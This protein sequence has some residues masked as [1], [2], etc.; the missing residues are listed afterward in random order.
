MTKKNLLKKV[1]SPIICVALLLTY[2]PFSSS[3]AAEGI[4]PST[5]MGIVTDPGT[6]DSF[7]NMMGTDADGN[8]YA[9]RVWVDKSVYKNGDIVTLNNRN[10][11]GS[12]FKVSLEDDEAFQVVF[13]ALGSTM[14]TKKTMISSGPLDVVLI[15]DTSTSMEDK[16]KNVT[17]LERT[18]A[19]ANGLIDDILSNKDT[20]ISVV[21]YNVDS[22]TVIPLAPYKNGVDLVVTNYLNNNKPDAG[23]VTA[24]DNDKN[25]LGKDNGYT[26]GTNLQSGIDRGFNILANA[27]NTENRT[28][29]A[30]V[31]T[32]G[33]ATLASKEGYYE[34]ESQVN[35][36]GVTATGRNLYLTTLLN[37]AYNKTKVEEKYNTD[38]LVYTVGVDITT[39]VRA[40]LLM[41][42]ADTKNG[43]NANNSNGEVKKAYENFGKWANGETVTYSGWT[44]DHN[45]PTQNGLITD[46][47]IAANVNYS[48]VYYDVTSTA[49][50]DAFKQIYEE[51][52]SG[53]F[54]PISS[55]TSDVGGTGVDDTPLIYVDFIGQYMEIKSIQSVSIF[56]SS[57]GVIKNADGT[58]S[59]D[60]GTGVNP[61]TNEIWK[62][63]EDITFDIIPQDDGTQKFE[64]RINQE[65]LP[66]I[67]EQAISETVGNKT[68]S[69]INEILQDPLRVYY[70]VGLDSDILLPNGDINISKIQGYEYIDADNGTV[71]FYSNRFGVMN[72][73]DA[74]DIV[75]KG[76]AHVGFLPSHENRYYYNQSNHGI[77][78]K[79]TDKKTGKDVTIP[80]NNE[81]G[82]VW[83]D[84]QYDLTWMTYDEYKTAD[85]DTKVYTYVTFYR[86]TPDTTDA[87]NAAEQVTYLRYADWKYIKE[88]V[89]FYDQTAKAYLNNGNAIDVKDVDSVISA[90]KQNNP[91]AEL[92]AVL[93]I[94][95]H[96]SSRLHNM[97]VNKSENVT[98]TAVERYTPEYTYETAK[99]HSGNEVVV[100]LGNN[101]KLTL[102]LDTGIALTKNV[103]EAIG[104]PFDTYALTVTVPAGVTANPEVVDANGKVV[105]YTYENN[106]LTVNVKAKET[107]Y[108]S[109]IPGGTTCEIDEII[110]GDYYIQ[111][112]TDTVTIPN[113]SEV[114]N[115]AEQFVRA[116]VTNVPHKHGNLFITKEITSNHAVPES[117][118]NELFDITVSL[119]KDLANR[120]FAVKDMEHSESYEKTTDA[121]GNLTLQI[122]ARQTIEILRIP[123]GTNV[124]VTENN[125]DNH[126]AVSY[127][128]RNHSGEDADTDNA[129]VIPTEG[130]ATA[131]VINHYTPS[132]VSVDL[133]I[134]G[135]KNFTIEGNHQGGKFT[136]KTQKWNGTTWEDI[137]GKTAETEYDDNESGTKNFTIE[138]VLD[139]IVFDEVGRYS[140]QVVEVKGNV[141]NITYDRTLYTFVVNVTDNGGQLVAN[142]TDL[143]NKPITDGSYE[144]VFNNTYH[145]APVSLDVKKIVDNKSGD[146]TI[147]PAG[148]EFKAISTDANWN[149]LTGEDASS[150][151]IYSD[152]VGEA[153]FNSVCT[154]AGTYYFVLTEVDKGGAG[155]TYSD[156]EYHITVAVSADDATGNL[157]ASLNIVKVG[158]D[159]EH[160]IASVDVNDATKGAVS[161]VNTYDPKDV[162][163]D[164]DGVVAKDL[165]GKDLQSNQ[166][167]FY[168]Y[169]NEDR[170]TPVLEGKNGLNG[171]V[172]LVD[173]N[174]VLTFTTV[175][176]FEYDIVEYIPEN[177]VYDPASGKYILNGMSYDATIYD[178]VVEVIN[179]TATGELKAYYYFEDAVTNLVTFYNSYKVE[180]V[181]YT[182][183]GTKILHGR[184]PKTGE[185]FFELYEGNILKETVSNKSDGSFTFNEIIYIA[186][187]EYTYTVKEKNGNKAG[188]RYDGVNNPITIVVTVVDV[189]GVLNATAS[190]D[191]AN[192]KFE[193]Y[194]VP[195]PAKVVFN[196]VKELVGGE[197]VDN[198][199]TFNLYKTDYFF[200]ITSDTAELIATAKNNNGTF[201][202]EKEFSETGTHYF[203]VAENTTENVLSNVVYDRTKHLLA[204]K[205]SDIGDGQLK[206]DVTNV[207]TGVVTE[208]DALV[209][210]NVAFTNAAFD[211][212]TKKEVY[213][214]EDTTTEINGKE[215][216][217]GDVLTYFITYTNY[218]GE[219]VV[220]NITD[221]IPANATYVEG[222]AT[223]DGTFAGD[224]VNW[225]LNVDKEETVTVSFDVEVVGANSSIVNKAIIRDG[226]NTYVTNE[227]V[228]TVYKPETHPTTETPTDTP[229][230]TDTPSTGESNNLQLWIV[231]LFVSCGGFATVGIY[232]KKRKTDQNK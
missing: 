200:D 180:Y 111:S 66:I 22:E 15:L 215:V 2:I 68:T 82:I 218:T 158:S 31:L 45:Y 92:Y 135:T 231:L 3:L 171:N 50:Q 207:K 142:I 88:S 116:S 32:D 205:V 199:F 40:K 114:L 163:V 118:L 64:I 178:L 59:V 133:D 20:R 124:T 28:P 67:M 115:G 134:I 195:N 201:S 179:D 102:K 225:I 191:N 35:N 206:A 117:V 69:T 78:T 145:T 223:L 172:N 49:L 213:L 24:Y 100:W 181:K 84:D 151:S 73:A 209:S 229:T 194:Y 162:I 120:S 144:V 65:I 203:V 169:K 29:V 165:F 121:S 48:D 143:N 154:K 16:Y 21:T 112:K 160:E 232:D 216:N 156:A 177:A 14:T 170:T 76:D 185:F 91:N 81:Y 186:E 74:S 126:F 164:L 5:V 55:S 98:Q 101:G 27:T 141:S 197:L 108:I 18:I 204:V 132:P 44:F 63:N 33:Q 187:G 192:V 196:G 130:S 4:N 217:V 17:R 122:K 30:I 221:A 214:A 8:R 167:T 62:T 176:K 211:G 56:G 173:F 157:T 57:Y 52:S 99:D 138:N 168:V 13:S 23:V 93:G 34:L 150:I 89:A 53:A 41:N 148:F 198:A 183:S 54:N 25:V 219:N 159:N 228:N 113:V 152:A 61:T 190:V 7:E 193:N 128:T 72:P 146:D 131:V 119:G 36:A 125:S 10:E 85:D 11:T 139:G 174:D 175:G 71:S 226:V 153:R 79:I 161:F 80:E 75:A 43:F 109:G 19:A 212:V 104:N 137:I 90:Y 230:A 155:W 87:A 1:L 166:F 182:I 106:I 149:P 6:A 127:R 26:M 189:N 38:A 184:A 37:A 105:L 39:N 83:N 188:I 103:T 42:P 123:A 140:Y 222:S 136:Y 60:V 202:F 220:A 46:A 70:T 47:K 129:L 86:P 208:R 12:S 224:H 227:V 51:I 95:S 77:F 107:V 147:S 9:G 94:G 210:V 97:T 58:Y 110:K 96:R